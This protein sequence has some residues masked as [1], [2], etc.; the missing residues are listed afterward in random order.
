MR[1]ASTT[2]AT[3]RTAGTDLLRVFFF[4]LLTILLCAWF[5]SANGLPGVPSTEPASVGAASAGTPAASEG[6]QTITP[7]TESLTMAI[8]LEEGGVIDVDAPPMGVKI[9]KWN[10]DD[11]LLV[12]EKTKRPK[13]GTKTGTVDPV[14]IQVSRKGKNV[15][16]ETTGGAGWEENGMDLSFRIVLPERYGDEPVVRRSKSETAARLTGVL[17]RALHN[18][19]LD[20]LTR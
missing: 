13:T 15:R 4:V 6:A 7:E 20:W 18:E 17:W 10:G 19:A 12:V 9:S 11:V 5:S 16:I 8:P 1:R 3:A 14:N 2:V